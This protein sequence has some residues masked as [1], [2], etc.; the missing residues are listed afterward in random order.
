MLVACAACVGCWDFDGAYEDWCARNGCEARV[1]AGSDA[2]AEPD[3]GAEREDAGVDAGTTGMDAGVPDA[4]S[5][6]NCP[7]AGTVFEAGF[8]AE[9]GAP[10]TTLEAARPSAQFTSTDLE[11]REGTRSAR[12]EVADGDLYDG[13]GDERALLSWSGA[14]PEEGSDDYFGWSTFVPVPGLPNSDQ[15]YIV[16]WDTPTLNGPVAV[17]IDPSTVELVL[18]SIAG[19]PQVVTLSDALPVGQWQD[20]VVHI[21]WSSNPL[22]G[23]AEGWHRRGGDSAWG[24]PVKVG[25]ATLVAG[26]DVSLQLGITRTASTSGTDVILHDAFRRAKTFCG[27]APRG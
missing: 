8:E 6:Y 14:N 26:D 5:S 9:G 19:L 25:G 3:A 13:S 12:F 24:T 1:D 23:Y 4:G 15:R 18:E 2:G 10:F 11:S 7:D 22:A 17:R 16:R 20:F 27:A 21:H